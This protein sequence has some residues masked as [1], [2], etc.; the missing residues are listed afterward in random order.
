[1]AG[2]R[3][4]KRVILESSLRKVPPSKIL[5]GDGCV[6]EARVV[7]GR[8]S[9]L[10]LGDYVKVK[11]GTRIGGIDAH[12]K[13]LYLGSNSWIG[14]ET[15][16]NTN[17]DVELGDNVGVGAR[18]EI[19]THGYF[20]NIADGYPYKTGKVVVG[21][22]VW[23]PPSCIILPDVE[24]GANTIVGTGSVITKSLPPDVFATGT[25][26]VVK[27]S[28][29]WKYRKKLDPTQKMELVKEQF[30][31]GIRDLGFSA[32]EDGQ[33]RYKISK[34]WHKFH[35][36]FDG[37]C[38]AKPS[39]KEILFVADGPPSSPAAGRTVIDITS[40][41]YCKTG[42]LAEWIAIRVLLD[43]CVLRLVAA[44]KE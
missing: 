6:I 2:A 31:A 17:E 29:Q 41:T 24:I 30:L 9:K 7:I 37:E 5:I 43:R 25:P 11:E 19:W 23:L 1:L 18:S 36:S 15:T 22:G 42:S 40:N 12:P 8:L 21:T 28:D 26:C 10:T 32:V 35:V 44:Q 33:D 20:S 14:E 34:A 13:S 38:Q 39:G 4:G 27:Q 3:I 16:I